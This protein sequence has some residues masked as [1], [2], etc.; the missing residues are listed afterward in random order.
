M[1]QRPE[2]K[3]KQYKLE[4]FGRSKIKGLQAGSLK[5][6]IYHNFHRSQMK[7]GPHLPSLH[8]G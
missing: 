2:Y 7:S 3:E 1:E 5:T 4:S 6:G 8:S